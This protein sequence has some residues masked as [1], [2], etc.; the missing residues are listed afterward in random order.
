[1]NQAIEAYAEHLRNGVD[2]TTTAQVIQAQFGLSND[3]LSIVADAGTRD[4]RLYWDN[5]NELSY[6]RK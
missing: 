1:M 6:E 5:I 3:E 2:S 4:A